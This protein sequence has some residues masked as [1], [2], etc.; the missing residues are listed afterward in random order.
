MYVSGIGVEPFY[1]KLEEIIVTQYLEKCCTILFHCKWFDT[2]PTKKRLRVMKNITS[3]YVNGEWYKN[4]AFVLCT[5][6]QQVFYTE[7][8]LNSPS[9]NV[10][11]LSAHRHV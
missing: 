8:L 2:D 3:V 4:D 1:G 9:W 7:D 11:H 10:A 6:A 5:Q